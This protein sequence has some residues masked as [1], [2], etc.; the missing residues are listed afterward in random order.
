M[1]LTRKSSAALSYC[2]HSGD[3][4]YKF[5]DTKMETVLSH[6]IQIESLLVDA[7]SRSELSIHYQ[8]F[9]DT[10]TQQ[11]IGAEALLRWNN[12]ELGCVSPTDFIA[13][14]EQSGQIIEIGYFVLRSGIQQAAYGDS[15]II[16]IFILLLMSHHCS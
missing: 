8:P 2:D 11:V 7:L 15:S 5:F 4:S 13:I 3:K 14:A 16:Q 12:A 6:R 10:Q 1:E 9:V